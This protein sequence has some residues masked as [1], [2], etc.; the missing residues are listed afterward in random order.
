[1]A[2]RLRDNAVAC[3][4]QYDGEVSRRTT[5]DHITRILFV[6]RCICDDKLAL[7]G[8]KIAISDVDRDA[9]FAL[10]LESVE[11]ECVVD[12]LASVAYALTVAPKRYELVLV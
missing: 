8:G 11:Q 1:M 7:I 4:Y 6:P 12:V 5:C 2:P 3:I 9:F 10:S